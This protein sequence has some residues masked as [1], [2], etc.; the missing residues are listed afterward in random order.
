MAVDA[1]MVAVTLAVLAL[2]LRDKRLTLSRN[3]AFTA[4]VLLGVY[5][6]LPRII[7]GS[8][9]ADMRLVPFVIAVAVLAIRFRF[10]TDLKFARMLAIGGVGLFLAKVAVTTVSLGIA[11]QRQ[12]EAMEALA[13]LPVGAAS[14]TLVGEPCAPQWRL[15]RD[16]HLAAMA[17]VRRR[18]FTND[19]WAIEGANLLTVKYRDA[20]PFVADPSQMVKPNGCGNRE[21]MEV[22]RAL[23]RIPRGAV[24]HLWAIDL[25]PHDPRLLAGMAPLWRGEHAVLY[26]V[27]AKPGQRGQ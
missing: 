8:A 18:A 5:L 1:V 2:A 20:R 10:A 16:S 3:L 11:A 17:T 9:Y 21:R 14:I 19:Q 12:S 7:F 15:H 22:D 27:G 24:T 25:P 13:H 23:Q 4:L 26:E 6:L